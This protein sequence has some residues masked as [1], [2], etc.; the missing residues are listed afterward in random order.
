MAVGCGLSES[1][2]NDVLLGVNFFPWYGFEPG[3]GVSVSGGLGS[4]HWNSNAIDSDRRTGA[5]PA[6][7][8]PIVSTPDL[9]FYISDDT[10][11]IEQQVSWMIDTGID[12]IMVNWW[13]W[14]D[15]DLDDV[16]DNL[17]RAAIERA[18][19]A[20]FDHIEP[21]GGVIKA[22]IQSENW[23]IPVEE[24]D[25][26][27]PVFVSAG[28]SQTIWDYVSDEYVDAYPN[29]YFVWESKPLFVSGA[30]HVLVADT[31]SRFTYKKLWPVLFSE[32][33][34]HDG[35]MDWSWVDPAA[36]DSPLDYNDE[37]ISGDGVV[38]VTNRRDQYWGWIQ[39]LIDGIPERRDP[40]LDEGL[41]DTNWQLVFGA[42]ETI[43]LVMIQTWNDYHEMSF[44]EPAGVG[45]LGSKDPV[46]LLAKTKFYGELLKAGDDFADYRYSL[47]WAQPEELRQYV[48]SLDP[49]DLGMADEK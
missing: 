32:T 33:D 48:A 7:Y 29:S 14:G 31:S 1:E 40:F 37:V 19:K 49:L 27:S 46:D 15:D 17:G 44:I 10:D 4:E 3:T 21:L 23:M 45:V 11:V 24:W 9:G 22:F 34:I 36:V 12:V 43:G 30:P 2:G 47:L 28:D 38:I 8:D 26:G 13:G 6:I 42:D 35:E 18:T 16:Q 25:A 5:I 20:L 41:G 39:G